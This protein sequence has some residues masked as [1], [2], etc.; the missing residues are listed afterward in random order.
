VQLWYQYTADAKKPM[1]IMAG[2]G[3]GKTTTLVARVLHMALQQV[4][5][6]F[7]VCVRVKLLSAKAVHAI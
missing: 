1:L 6:C 5:V 3:S 2:A 7:V 4:C